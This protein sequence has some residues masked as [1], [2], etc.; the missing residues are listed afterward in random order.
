MVYVRVE[1]EVRPTEDLNKV[2]KALN[3]VVAVKNP[4]V[5]DLGRERKLIVAEEESLEPLKR[6]YEALRR[7][8]ILDSARAVLLKNLRGNTVEVKLNKQAA[9]Q[10]VI[11]FVDQDSESPLG[12]IRIT[13]SSSKIEMIVDWLTPRT[14]H[15]VPLWEL[16]LPSD[17]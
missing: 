14:A 9:Y 3:N 12:P 11:S 16:E 7:Q 13:I 1:V 15:G 17:V 8:R 6:L 5:E 2:L 4:R 10:G